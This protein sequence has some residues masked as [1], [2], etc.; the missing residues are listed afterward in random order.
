MAR[1]KSE[2]KLN[3]TL[4]AGVFGSWF[5]EKD[6]PATAALFQKEDEDVHAIIE[7]AK[8]DW[9]RPRPPLQDKRIQP[10]IDLPQNTSY[11]S[12]HSTVGELDALILAELA[13]DLKE[14][15]M[16]RGRQI[17]DD[18]I[19]AG[20][21]FPSDVEAGRTLGHA[22]FAKLMASPAFQADLAQAKAEIAAVRA[23]H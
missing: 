18:R 9:N 11:P 5:T 13:P 23:K 6:L 14:A 22:L 8:K 20:V 12:G 7:M 21:H 15:I 19:I 16:A 1:I 2:T 17:G 3:V 10:P 4:F